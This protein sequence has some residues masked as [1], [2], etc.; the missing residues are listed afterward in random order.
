MYR[1]YLI[2]PT[3]SITVTRTEQLKMQYLRS[4]ARYV[5]ENDNND[6]P[7]IVTILRTNDMRQSQTYLI[8][9]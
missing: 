3:T 8:S 2:P 9:I 4:S 5:S 1:L 7:T 6:H